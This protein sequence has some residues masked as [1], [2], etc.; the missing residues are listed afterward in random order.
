MRTTLHENMAKKM[1][2]HVF[3]NGEIVP[4]RDAKVSV[5]DRGLLYGDGLFETIRVEDGFPL[6][7]KA[8]LDRLYNSC[9]FL[10]IFLT[11]GMST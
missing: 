3:I 1:N 4:V 11:T 2:E 5:F 6:F 10:N 7:L 9:R 8:H